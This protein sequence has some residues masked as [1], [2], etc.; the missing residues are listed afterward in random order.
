MA[1]TNVAVQLTHYSFQK[2]VVQIQ[3]VKILGNGEEA[4][5][6]NNYSLPCPSFSNWDTKSILWSERSPLLGFG[7]DCLTKL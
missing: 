2:Q 6:S 1:V 3:N 7:Y 5:G 4:G